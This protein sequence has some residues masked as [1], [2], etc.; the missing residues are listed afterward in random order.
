MP[1]YLLLPTMLGTLLGAFITGTLFGRASSLMGRQTFSALFSGGLLYFV[2]FAVLFVA[3]LLARRRAAAFSMMCM[4]VVVG[5]SICH[6]LGP[7]QDDVDYY[8]SLS[9]FLDWLIQFPVSL[10]AL[11]VSVVCWFRKSPAV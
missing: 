6:L 3:T 9:L 5:V 7:V 11:I 1:K 2:P 8:E 4:L 10:L